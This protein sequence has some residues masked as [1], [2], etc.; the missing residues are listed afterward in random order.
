MGDWRIQILAM[1]Q[2]FT[3]ITDY[4]SLQ[5]LQHMKDTS[6]QLMRGYLALQPYKFEV[7]YC[8][9]MLA[10][11]PIRPFGPPWTSKPIWRGECG[12]EPLLNYEPPWGETGQRI[13][14]S[15]Q[16]PAGSVPQGQATQADPI[17]DK[18]LDQLYKRLGGTPLG[19]PGIMAAKK[20]ATPTRHCSLT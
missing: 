7:Q 9:L 20:P 3:V 16:R 1:C 5:R 15:K 18:L 11:F 6:L 8:M 12:C 17:S 13:T 10:S 19:S 4:A 14:T 2:Q